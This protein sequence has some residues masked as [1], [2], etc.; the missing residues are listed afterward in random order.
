MTGVVGL[1]I[2][3]ERTIKVPCAECGETVLVIGP[4]AGPHIASLRCAVCDRHR[5]WLPKAAANFLEASVTLFGR[6]T[7][8]ITVRS[9][10]FAPMSETATPGAIA[11]SVPAPMT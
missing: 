5:G 11:A 9:S 6:P 10:Q 3:L 8:P 1:Q 4:G 7:E 2:K